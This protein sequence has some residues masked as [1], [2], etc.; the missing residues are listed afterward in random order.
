MKS[1][2]KKNYGMFDGDGSDCLDC[3]R[4]VQYCIEL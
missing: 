4:S 1:I 3:G 2:R